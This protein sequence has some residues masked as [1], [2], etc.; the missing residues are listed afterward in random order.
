[1]GSAVAWG[2]T[3]PSLTREAS[4]TV[5]SCSWPCPHVPRRRT[6]AG[7]RRPAGTRT[8]PRGRSRRGAV[9][10]PGNALGPE[11]AQCCCRQPPPREPSSKLVKGPLGARLD[12]PRLDPQPGPAAGARHPGPAARVGGHLSPLL[13]RSASLPTLHSALTATCPSPAGPGGV[14]GATAHPPGCRDRCLQDGPG[15]WGRV[16]VGGTP[17]G[18]EG[19]PGVQATGRPRCD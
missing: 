12:V 17:A 19:T 10:R 5:S 7:T 2:Q 8:G 14:E 18:A 6:S 13:G 15:P 11:S 1:M 16:A 9:A 4:R 3:G